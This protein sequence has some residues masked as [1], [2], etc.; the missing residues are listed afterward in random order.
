MTLKHFNTASLS[1]FFCLTDITRKITDFI[2]LLR[3]IKSVCHCSQNRYFGSKAE[4][5]TIKTTETFAELGYAVRIM[6]TIK[7]PQKKDENKNPK[8]RFASTKSPM[9]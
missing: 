7:T 3:G 5:T 8:S 9:N 4:Q 6:Q 2:H 1:L